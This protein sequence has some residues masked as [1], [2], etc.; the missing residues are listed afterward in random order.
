MDNPTSKNWSPMKH[1]IWYH[2]ETIFDGLYF[3]KSFDIS[4]SLY[5]D[6][7]WADSIVNWW[8][9]NIYLVYLGKNVASWNYCKQPIV[10]RF[11]TKVEYKV[12]ANAI[13][14]LIWIFSLLG[15]LQIYLVANL[16]F[17]TCTKHIEI[18][19]R[20]VHEQVNSKH[21]KISFFSTKDQIANILTNS[22]PKHRFLELKYKLNVFYVINL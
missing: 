8:S 15:E 22:L 16:L 7:D 5:S 1:L 12:V 9:I 3:H 17:H 13:L 20:Y 4:L 19:Y 10:L 2:K 18:N 14:E 6:V 21:I 11:N